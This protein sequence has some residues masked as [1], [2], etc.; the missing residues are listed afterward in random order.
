VT[1]NVDL[2]GGSAEAVLAAGTVVQ[3][4]LVGGVG[5]FRRRVAQDV[6]GAV[7]EFRDL[8]RAETDVGYNGG[9]G[10]RLRL[11]GVTPFI[12][13]RYYSVATSPERTNFLPV[14]VGFTF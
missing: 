9:V 11:A 10:V 12:E 4:Y 7:E 13:A 1:G 2:L 5:V 3:P 14:T 8:T 6:V